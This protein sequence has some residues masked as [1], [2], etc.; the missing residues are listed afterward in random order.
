L[1]T[2]LYG[3]RTLRIIAASWNARALLFGAIQAGQA[4]ALRPALEYATSRVLRGLRRFRTWGGMHRL[5]P[6]HPL[7]AI[8][9][10]GWWFRFGDWDAAGS[11]DT[12]MK[13][14]SALTARRH[15]ASLASTAR[16]IADLGDMDANWFALLGGQDGWLGSTTLLDQTRLWRDGAYI[17]VP[18][19]PETVRVSFHHLTELRP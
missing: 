6:H 5:E 2:A 18:L 3:R 17:Q 12:L 9:L 16:H 14:A 8:P 7:A 1:A 10:L 4:E 15:H 13:T 19:R 11:S